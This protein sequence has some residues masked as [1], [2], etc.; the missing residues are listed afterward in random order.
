MDFY[1]ERSVPEKPPYHSS[2][3][4]KQFLTAPRSAKKVPSREPPQ[5]SLN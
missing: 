4:S 2:R 3:P 1:V 5:R